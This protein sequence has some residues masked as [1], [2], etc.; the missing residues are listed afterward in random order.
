MP[1]LD[2]VEVLYAFKTTIYLK[3][4]LRL[5]KDTHELPSQ[6]IENILL[7]RLSLGSGRKKD[8][9]MAANKKS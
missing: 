3:A 6:A 1:F 9:S 7:C 8:S 2:T 5:G 4:P